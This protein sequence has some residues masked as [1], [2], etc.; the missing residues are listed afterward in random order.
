MHYSIKAPYENESPRVYPVPQF[1][2]GVYFPRKWAAWGAGRATLN[3]L[4]CFAAAE[5]EVLYVYLLVVSI[6][7]KQ[8]LWNRSS[9]IEESSK[10]CGVLVT[11][12]LSLVPLRTCLWLFGC[13]NL[14]SRKNT[15]TVVV[16]AGLH[17]SKVYQGFWKKRG[18]ATASATTKSQPRTI[19]AQGTHNQPSESSSI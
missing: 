18:P 5:D 11:S 4:K 7:A 13:T 1:S 17:G 16:V 15:C 14:T 9:Y 12:C 10:N 6:L 3:I 8:I 19:H 2:C